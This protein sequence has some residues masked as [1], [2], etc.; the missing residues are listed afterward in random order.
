MLCGAKLPFLF[1]FSSPEKSRQ[2]T[3]RRD[4]NEE[5]REEKIVK[6]KEKKE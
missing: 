6:S 2:R 4:K 5:K 3:E 1:F